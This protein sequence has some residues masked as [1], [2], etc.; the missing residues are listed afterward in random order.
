R[1]RPRS[2]HGHP[3]SRSRR[4]C[5]APCL[6]VAIGGQTHRVDDLLVPRTPAQVS[7]QGLPDLGVARRG[8]THI[9]RSFQQVIGLYEQTRGAKPALDRTGVDKS[10]LHDPQG[11]LPGVRTLA[12]PLH[13]A[14]APPFGLPRGDHARTRGLFVEVDGARTTLSLFTGVLAPRK[15]QVLTPHV[16]QALP[17]PDVVDGPL[18]AVEVKVHTH[19]TPSL[20]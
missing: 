8:H 16:Q 13:S 7:G 2:P 9:H 20:R 5:G 6:D 3:R 17:G 4:S 12:Q 14:Y 1:C 10:L 11:P 18:L 19:R 15:T